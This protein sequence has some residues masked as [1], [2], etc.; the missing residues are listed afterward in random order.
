MQICLKIAVDKIFT[1]PDLMF[2]PENGRINY[3]YD[4]IYKYKDS[5]YIV[6]YL[7]L[8][9]SVPSGGSPAFVSL[10]PRIACR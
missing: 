5:R 7:A 1:F 3:V 10:D 6:S 8:E 2:S 4:S 9:K